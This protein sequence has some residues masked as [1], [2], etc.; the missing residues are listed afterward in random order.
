MTARAAEQKGITG[1]AAVGATLNSLAQ[2]VTD[3]FK[4]TYCRATYQLALDGRVYENTVDKS[5]VRLV[6]GSVAVPLLSTISFP[7]E[8]RI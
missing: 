3:T 2:S 4:R 7:S 5:A 6:T 8:V 1:R